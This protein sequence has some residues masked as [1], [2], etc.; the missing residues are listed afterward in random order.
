MINLLTS[1]ISL[2]ELTTVLES[3]P[4]LLPKLGDPCWRRAARN[5]LATQV[6]ASAEQ[7][8]DQQ[9]PE[10]TDDLYGDFH[11]TG[12]RL[13]FERVY[14]E[15][16]RRLALTA[17]TLLLVEEHAGAKWIESLISKLTDIFEE[18]SWALPAHVTVPSG[19]DPTVIDLFA[20][21][22]A[23]ILAEMVTV[24]DT[25]LPNEL[26]GDIRIRLRD[27]IFERYVRDH[28]TLG[29]P[30]YANNWNAVCHQGVLGAALG[31]E[32]DSELVARMFLTAKDYLPIFLG[33]FPSDGGCSEGP[34]YWGYG[35]GWFSVLNEQIETATNGAVSLFDGDQHIRAIAN[36]PVG[37]VMKNGY[38]VNFAD[39][40]A[41]MRFNPRLL[42]YLGER[43]ENSM[44][45]DVAADSYD[46]LRAHGFTLGDER[47][48][49]FYLCRLFRDM[50]LELPSNHN[51]LTDSYFP[52][53]AVACVHRTDAQ[54]RLWELAVKGGTNAEHH[55]HNDCG[56]FILHIDGHPIAMEI[57][58]P[59]YTKEFFGPTRYEFLA[60]R[61]FGHSVPVVN[62]YEQAA[63]SEYV[64]TMQP[65]LAN[66]HRAEFLIDLTNCYPREAQCRS[67]QRRIELDLT[68]GTCTVTDR[69]EL[70]RAVSFET[71]IICESD[72]ALDGVNA[73]IRAD[74]MDMCVSPDEVSQIKQVNRLSFNDHEGH[75]KWIN[76]IVLEPRTM[77]DSGSVGYSFTVR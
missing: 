7:V 60:A 14:F 48:D 39:A 77:S 38:V 47:C 22:T 5:P 16:R 25:V 59:E 43:L 27:Q 21:E 51:I 74:D 41:R 69:F 44:L 17:I 56:S 67:L 24:F 35:F 50:P 55:N 2:H 37:V 6:I 62:G 20:A 40:A 58:A 66:D 23:N 28:A 71:A 76:R 57:G 31:I 54:G 32:E 36:Y 18:E 26:V 53:L 29:F 65:S 15:R 8:R 13:N 75:E 34:G 46:D 12:L 1:D 19:K 3:R 49:F 33:G 68:Q 4:P 45:M 11:R 73:V 63:G 10:L 70:I 52:D 30:T 42:Q 72:V 9:L 61:S 64:S